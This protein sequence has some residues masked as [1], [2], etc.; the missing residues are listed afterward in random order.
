MPT[1]LIVL[2]CLSHFAEELYRAWIASLTQWV[3]VQSVDCFPYPVGVCAERGL[4]PLPSCFLYRAWIASLT[5][6]VSV[7]CMDCF[8]YPVGVYTERGLLPLPSG[9]LC[10]AWIAFLTS[11]CLCRTWVASPTQW[12]SVKGVDCL[13]YPVGV[14]AGC[15]LPPLPSECLCRAWVAS[16]AQW[17]SG[18]GVSRTQKLRSPLLRISSVQSLDRSGRHGDMKDS[19]AETLFQSFLQKALGSSSGVGMDSHSLMLS[20]QHFLCRPRRRLP[21]KVP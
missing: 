7:Q 1:S 19:S 5:Q 13:H 11:G 2:L 8:P 15:G 10:R 18:S 20:I 17:V 4:L 3:S 16:L 14:C 21:S 12:V 6:W 9:C